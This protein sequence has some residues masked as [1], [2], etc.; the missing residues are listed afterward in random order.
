MAKTK[1]PGG[2]PNAKQPSKTKRSRVL[3]RYFVTVSKIGTRYLVIW[4]CLN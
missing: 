4:N 2:I 1:P 3:P